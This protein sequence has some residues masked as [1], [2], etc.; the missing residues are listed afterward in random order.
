MR[1]PLRNEAGARDELLRDLPAQMKVLSV[2]GDYDGEREEVE[3]VCKEF[4]CQSWKIAVQGA[5]QALKA[6]SSETGTQ[7]IAK[8]TGA[9]VARWLE[10]CN[11]EM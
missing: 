11:E 4:K 10:S 9:M 1:Y 2:S 5:N 3:G 6:E 7:E 8:M